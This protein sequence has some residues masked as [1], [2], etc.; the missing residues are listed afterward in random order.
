MPS[1]RVRIGFLVEPIHP[2]IEVVR[3]DLERAFAEFGPCRQRFAMSRRPRSRIPRAARQGR[4]L[5][6]W[7]MCLLQTTV[8]GRGGEGSRRERPPHPLHSET[9][10]RAE[11]VA[12]CAE[13]EAEISHSSQPG[14]YHSVV[15]AGPR[16]HQSSRPLRPRLGRGERVQRPGVAGCVRAARRGGGQRGSAD[17]SA[18]ACAGSDRPELGHGRIDVTAVYLGRKGAVGNLPRALIQGCGSARAVPAL[19]RRPAPSEDLSTI[20]GARRLPV[21]ESLPSLG[22]E[23]EYGP[24]RV[25]RRTSSPPRSGCRRPGPGVLRTPRARD[26]PWRRAV[27]VGVRPHCRPASLAWLCA[28]PA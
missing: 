13:R 24:P 6:A 18:G 9:V 8:G 3:I 25:H 11:A 12:H 27:Y 16:G 21:L 20:L 5:V 2:L 19:H 10:H 4:H 26:W 23:A 17:D 7:A 1:P 14:A 28:G 22:V 15:L